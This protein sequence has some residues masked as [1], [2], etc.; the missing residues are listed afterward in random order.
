MTKHVC[1]RSPQQIKLL[2]IHCSEVEL[3]EQLAPI[4]GGAIAVPE[5]M[6][7]QQIQQ[8][9]LILKLCLYWDFQFLYS[10]LSSLN[11]YFTAR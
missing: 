3:A 9:I 7:E 5:K 2:S 11:K 4:N 6:L 1:K 10:F 8:V